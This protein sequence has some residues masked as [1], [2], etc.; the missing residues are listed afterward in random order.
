MSDIKNSLPKLKK[1]EEVHSVFIGI[2]PGVNTGLAVIIDGKY[3]YIKSHSILMSMQY[4]QG[5]LELF[6][7]K[8]VEMI[9]EN[10][11]LRSYFGNTGRE[12]LQGAG[13]IKRDYSIWV[14]FSKTNNIK[15]AGVSPKEVG[16]SFD[17]VIIFKNATGWDKQT[18]KHARDAAKIIYKY[19]KK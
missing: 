12:K 10:P 15:M 3:V 4:I 6:D 13:S 8:C 2:D 16:S 14:E 18:S 19:Y 9:V 5:L 11:N 1:P 7:P 17:N